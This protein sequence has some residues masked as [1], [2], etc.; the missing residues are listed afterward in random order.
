[1]PVFAYLL[2]CTFPMQQTGLSGRR[3]DQNVVQYP[4]VDANLKNVESVQAPFVCADC[5]VLYS[6]QAQQ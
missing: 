2:S 1:M 4:A 3:P 6:R 5:V